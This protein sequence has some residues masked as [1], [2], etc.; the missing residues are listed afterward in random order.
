MKEFI[1]NQ[2]EKKDLKEVKKVIPKKVIAFV[3]VALL[4]IIII[5]GIVIY[6]HRFDVRNYITVSY[7][8]AN[9]YAS[10]EFSVDK[11]GLKNALIGDKTD[12]N[13]LS[14]INSLVNSIEVS[15]E[16]TDLSNGDKF[17]INISYD[18][19]YEE[20]AGVK[21]N[22]T[23]YSIRVEG[24]SSGTKISLFDNIEVT[25][26]GISP[27]ATVLITNNSEDEYLQSLTF[28]ADKTTNI[29]FGDTVIVSCKES[30]E[31][32]ARHGYLVD[33]LEASYTA[34]KLGEYINGV[35]DIDINVI[36][37]IVE[38]SKKAITTKTSD[39]TFRMLYKATAN[40]DYLKQANI[41][42]ASDI[43][44]VSKYLLANGTNGSDYNNILIL[45]FSATISNE[46]A[47]ETV[48]FAFSYYNSYITV[49]NQFSV[50]R[51]ESNDNYDVSTSLESLQNSLI[52]SQ[53]ERY[54]VYE[55]NN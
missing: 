37:E 8:G 25:F 29:S 17:E 49:D 16:A 14:A 4:A 2:R 12:A 50:I 19:S 54:T 41:E 52:N 22:L 48:Y 20:A 45:I 26:Q 30:Y 24:V 13:V 31:D 11:E 1:S 21:L 18:K 27:E 44:L 15:S 23:K 47:S 6:N 39:T 42:T 10:P 33:S 9:D 35:E 38:E 36:N 43:K 5:I 46:S 7:V 3:F 55:L 51:S 28:E 53:K 32:I 40:K 34:D